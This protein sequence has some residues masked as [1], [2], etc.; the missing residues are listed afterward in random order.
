MGDALQIY[1]EATTKFEKSMI[2]SEVLDEVRSRCNVDGGF[3]KPDG[4]GGYYEVGDHLAREKV[5]QSLRD[6]LSSKYKSSAKSK[7][8]RQKIVSVGV[9]NE[10]D[11]IIKR[12]SLV[13]RRMKTLQQTAQ[14]SVQKQ[15]MH[16]GTISDDEEQEIDNI[17]LKANLDILEAFKRND[18]LL[19]KFSESEYVHKS[20]RISTSAQ[21]A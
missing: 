11:S 16:G 6:G 20:R 1:G 19:E 10:F 5:G 2:V 15:I 7:K 14:N 8:R 3:V 9:A 13:T 21:A 18:N 17:F 4:N 12:N